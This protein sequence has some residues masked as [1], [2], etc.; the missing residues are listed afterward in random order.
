MPGPRWH[1]HSDSCLQFPC[2]HPP[3][4]I[5]INCNSINCIN[6]PCCTKRT[7]SHCTVMHSVS[8]RN[9]T[10]PV[11]DCDICFAWSSDRTVSPCHVS[12][13][14]FDFSITSPMQLYGCKTYVHFCTHLERYPRY[15]RYLMISLSICVSPLVKMTV[16]GR[17]TA[18][19]Q[20]I[21]RRCNPAT[22]FN[23][24]RYAPGSAIAFLRCLVFFRYIICS[25]SFVH[26]FRYFH[27]L[28]IILS[29][30]F[31]FSIARSRV[32]SSLWDS[33]A[34]QRALHQGHWRCNTPQCFLTLCSCWLLRGSKHQPLRHF[35]TWP[36]SHCPKMC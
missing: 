24:L 2:S 8:L 16:L 12:G 14:S 3:P 23:L 15:L 29:S 22:C 7:S 9:R 31:G 10:A 6:C 28:Y 1:S 20:G 19:K 5:R 11:P 30:F 4:P 34:M 27:L 21:C 25:C 13:D 36:L 35:S 32:V 33:S 18:W 26:Y 17:P